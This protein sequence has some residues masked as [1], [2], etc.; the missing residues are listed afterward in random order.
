MNRC[1]RTIAPFT[2]MAKHR[3]SAM[4]AAGLL[5]FGY[6]GAQQNPMQNIR[7]F[8]PATQRGVMIVTQPPELV[9]NDKA[10]RLS[11]GARIRGTD[12][13]LVMSGSIIGQKLRVNFVREPGGMVH[14]VWILSDAEAALKLPTQQ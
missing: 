13:M 6:A 10:D 5:T 9:L 11:P 7:P 12:N 8:P 4:L 1:T 2:N 14:E 3:F